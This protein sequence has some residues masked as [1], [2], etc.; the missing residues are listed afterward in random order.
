MLIN[1][2]LQYNSIQYNT[3]YNYRCVGV[4]D[5]VGSVYNT[6]DALNIKDTSLPP[7][8]DIA[9]HALA[10]QENRQRFLPTL[11]TLPETNKVKR[12][13][14]TQVLKQVCSYPQV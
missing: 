9:L 2:L 1:T 8:I 10:L 5:T 7:T 13:N 12:G 4:W 11:W 14:S 3:I 6:I